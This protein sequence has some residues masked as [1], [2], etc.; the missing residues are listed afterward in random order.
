[1]HS[2]KLAKEMGTSEEN[3]SKIEDIHELFY[4]M[5]SNIET[6]NSVYGRKGVAEMVTH[7][8]YTLQELWGFERN[9]NYHTY[10]Y[11]IPGCKCPESDNMLM[12]GVDHKVIDK[13]CPYHGEDE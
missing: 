6:Y 1:M 3:T 9:I 10:W 12:L 2:R 4:L 7:L 11:R 5:F 8:D 13:T